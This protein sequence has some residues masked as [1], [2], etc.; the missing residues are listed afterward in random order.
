MPERKPEPV[1]NSMLPIVGVVPGAG[2]I[3]NPMLAAQAAA[4]QV[5][6]LRRPLPVNAPYIRHQLTFEYKADQLLAHHLSSGIDLIKFTTP[7]DQRLRY[8]GQTVT[9]NIPQLGLYNALFY[10]TMIHHIIEPYFDVS[11]GYGFDWVTEVEAV[12]INGVTYDM[13]R[14]RGWTNI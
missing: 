2:G 8:A 3:N 13:G 10:M 4:S 6:Y 5:A 7:G 12:P 14:L 1:L 9:V 11:E